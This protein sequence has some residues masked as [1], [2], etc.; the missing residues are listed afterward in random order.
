MRK[1]EQLLGAGAVLAVAAALWP[2][3]DPA[4]PFSGVYANAFGARSYLG[5]APS[6]YE[7]GIALPLVVALHG[8]TETADAFRQL[9]RFDALAEARSFV[10]VFPQQTPSASFF[11]C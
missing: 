10:V 1:L 9:T 11:R 4:A 2:P 8:C 7:P 3:L 6:T 5:Y